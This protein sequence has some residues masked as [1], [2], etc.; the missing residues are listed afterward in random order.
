[1][2]FNK[3]VN[4]KR[5]LNEFKRQLFVP[6]MNYAIFNKGKLN[7]DSATSPKKILKNL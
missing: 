7:F 3:E 5:E 2:N 4:I 6:E 1:M